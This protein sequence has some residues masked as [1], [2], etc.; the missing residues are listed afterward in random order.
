V[1]GIVDLNGKS[2]KVHTLDAN[3][4]SGGFSCG[5][6][7]KCSVVHKITKQRDSDEIVAIDQYTFAIALDAGG[8]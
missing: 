2:A 4:M 8:Y 3:D 1:T 7:H 6:W 5:P